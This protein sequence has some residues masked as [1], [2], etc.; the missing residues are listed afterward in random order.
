MRVL[1][2][3]CVDWRIL[4]DLHPHD[5]RTVKQLGWQEVDDGSLLVRA[6]PEFDVFV[7]VDTKL[8]DQQNIAALDIAVVVLRGR[9]TRLAHLRELVDRLREVL[10]HAQPGELTIISWLDQR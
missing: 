8:P 6:A 4:R 9:S 3:E 5:A 1:V 10:S 7:T 2:D